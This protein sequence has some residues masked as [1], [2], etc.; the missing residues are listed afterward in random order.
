MTQ[1]AEYLNYHEDLITPER[2][3]EQ[4]KP[5]LER[6]GIN[7]DPNMDEAEV[8]EKNLVT[9]NPYEDPERF[10]AALREINPRHKGD[11]HLIRNALEA[12]HTV[13]DDETRKVIKDTAISYEMLTGEFEADGLPV[14][15]ET[16]L[17]G[18]HR[19]VIT[20][21]AR[22]NATLEKS[23]HAAAA[24]ESGVAHFDML[25]ISGAKRPMDSREQEEG[26]HFAPGAQTEFA[27][28]AATARV[29]AEENPG[30]AVTMLAV[31]RP[32]SNAPEVIDHVL[33]TM[34]QSGFLK[35][36][37]SIAVVTQQIYRY[38]TH[39]DLTR[40]AKQHGITE[41][42]VAGCKSDPKK[43]AARTDALYVSEI[44]RNLRAATET[45]KAEREVGAEIPE[46]FVSK[47]A[48]AAAIEREREER[49]VERFT[50]GSRLE[51]DRRGSLYL[52]FA[53]GGSELVRG[54]NSGDNTDLSPQAK[55]ILESKN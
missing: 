25:M 43:V 53:S 24:Q 5:F 16:P 49:I 10:E 4:A 11:R 6:F 17:T 19:L 55:L 8:E 30:M 12:D 38:W 26:A 51:V 9:I 1:E 14:Q 2:T 41:V 13:W 20:I 37:D 46:A 33:S 7:I 32:K 39:L 23:R 52:H 21:G 29:I 22:P 34:I 45:I 42:T 3:L 35:K 50:D 31:D 15:P 27:T 54:I 28:C 47:A 48:L 36:G 44:I 18:T 40:V